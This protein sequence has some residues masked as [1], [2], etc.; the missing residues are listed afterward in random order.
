MS[1]RAVLRVSARGRIGRYEFRG[2]DPF[3]FGD[4]SLTGDSLDL[5]ETRLT[6]EGAYRL[7]GEDRSLLYD[8]AVCC[9]RPGE[10][11]AR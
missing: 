10:L 1:D 6:V 3:R 4:V 7:N 2:G 5:Y 9:I 8:G 11:R